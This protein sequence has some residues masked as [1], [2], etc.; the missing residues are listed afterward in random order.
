MGA[1]LGCGSGGCSTQE[2]PEWSQLPT[3][4][5]WMAWPTV[6]NQP[7]L[8]SLLAELQSKLPRGRRRRDSME[9]ADALGGDDS[10]HVGS[11]E[12]H[13]SDDVWLEDSLPAYDYPDWWFGGC[14][15]QLS[16]ADV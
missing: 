6:D 14:P 3:A 7:R 9:K 11:P 2:Q 1:R 4:L 10:M 15:L 8:R 16:V 13:L 12:V 5:E